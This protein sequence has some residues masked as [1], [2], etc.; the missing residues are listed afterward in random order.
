LQAQLLAV[1]HPRKPDST[2]AH[3]IESSST[4]Q[5]LLQNKELNKKFW[6]E[7]V[8]YFPLI[9]QGSYVKRRIGQGTH[10]QQDDLMNLLTKIRGIYR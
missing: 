6:E 5:Q 9:R 2:T 7:I 1:Y 8:V 4:A 3:E 10:R